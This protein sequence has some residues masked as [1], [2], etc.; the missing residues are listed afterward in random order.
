MHEGRTTADGPERQK[1]YEEIQQILADDAPY[2]PLY[3]ASNLKGTTSKVND[4]VVLPNGSVR[5]QDA[6]LSE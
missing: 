5:F 1:I 2:I 6:W 3:F 4:F